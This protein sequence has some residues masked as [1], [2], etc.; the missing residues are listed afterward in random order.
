V[1]WEAERIIKE[2]PEDLQARKSG[3][4]IAM[5]LDVACS[6]FEIDFKKHGGL[7]R[8]IRK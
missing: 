8:F 6:F 1:T 2:L 7:L 4:N 5:G 3:G